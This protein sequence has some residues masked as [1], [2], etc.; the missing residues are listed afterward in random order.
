M[1][2]SLFSKGDFKTKKFLEDLKQLQIYEILNRYGQ[3]GVDV[4]RAATPEDT[5]LT[6]SK[7]GYEI[8][9]GADGYTIWFTNDNFNEGVNIAIILQYGHGTGT[10]GYFA[11]VDYINPSIGPVFEQLTDDAWNE[12][13][14]L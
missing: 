12:V 9:Q 7:W 6:A 10:G 2:F 11:G 14:K 8:E 5:G 1:R 13:T 3:L 4:L